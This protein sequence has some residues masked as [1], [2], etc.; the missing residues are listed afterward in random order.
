MAKKK[1]WITKAE[2]QQIIKTYE[3]HKGEII[4][5]GDEENHQYEVTTVRK[6]GNK[7]LGLIT[8][9]PEYT[10]NHDY[11][12]ILVA[13]SDAKGMRTFV[14]VWDRH[15]DGT[16]Y[17]RYRNPINVPISDRDYIE[18]L[19]SELSY[20]KGKLSILQRQYQNI[21]ETQST[22]KPAGRKPNP[23]KLDDQAKKIKELIDEGLGEKEIINKLGIIRSTYFRKKKRL[24]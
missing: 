15:A 13:H 14:D 4:P 12:R 21:I 5:Y 11:P 9:S 17:W 10:D 8:I 3:L 24:D 20:A 23:E 16:I 7:S 19:K 1:N 22:T 18:E 6:S 2:E